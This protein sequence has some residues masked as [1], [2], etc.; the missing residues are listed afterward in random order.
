MRH[1][2]NKP[3]VIEAAPVSE[4]LRDAEFDWRA[5]PEW[6]RS[7]YDKGEIVFTPIA[8]YIKTPEGDQ[9]GDRDD[10]VIRDAQGDIY[11]RNARV[12]AA[13]YEMVEP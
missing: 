4:V 6:V 7:A 3:S 5:L 8:V 11:V 9:R 13:A 1:F 10:W 12:F 2:R